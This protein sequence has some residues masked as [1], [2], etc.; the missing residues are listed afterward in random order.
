MSSRVG[1]EGACGIMGGFAGLRKAKSRCYHRKD[2]NI[3]QQLIRM[4]PIK[5]ERRPL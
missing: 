2:P 3:M 1:R 4:V 5:S